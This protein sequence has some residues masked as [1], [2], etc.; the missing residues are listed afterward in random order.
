M[1]AVPTYDPATGLWVQ[2]DQGSVPVTSDSGVSYSQATWDLLN[3]GVGV[4]L[5]DAAPGIG[6]LGQ[7]ASQATNG[8]VFKSG[9]PAQ[10]ASAGTP[11]SLNTLM[12]IGGIALLAFVFFEKA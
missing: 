8:Q 12:I 9:Q 2:Q 5:A 11:A 3:K 6:S 10:G 4:L 1:A 7:D